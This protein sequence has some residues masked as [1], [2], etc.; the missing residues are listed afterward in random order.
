MV[1]RREME[2]NIIPDPDIDV[3]MKILGLDICEDT[4]VGNAILKGISK[5]QRKRVTIGETLVGPLKSLF[6]D[7]ISIGLDDS[8]AFQIVKSLKQFVY[9]L[10]RTAVISLQQ[11]SLET[12]NLFDD[13]I[14]LSDGHIVYQGPC[15]QVLDFFASIGFMCPERKPVVDFLQEVTSM[16]D[17]EQYWTHKEKPYIFVTAKEFADAFESYHVGKSLANELATQFDKSKSHPAALTTN[18]YGIGKLELFKACLSRDYLLMKRNSSHYIFKLLQIA[19][20]AIITMTVFLPT[21]THHDSVT[22]GGI[23]ASALFY[24]STV[25]MLNGFAELAMMVG[26]LPV[27]YKQRDLLFF[28]SWAYALPAWILRLPLNFAEVGV[29]V[30]FTYSIIGDPNVIGR[31]FLLL[32]LV[33]QMAGVFCRLVG[34]IGRETSMAATLATL[35][36][37]ML[38]VVVSQ[39]IE[40]QNNLVLYAYTDNIKK[41]WLWEF[42]ISPAMYGQNALLNNEFQGKTWRHVVPN[43]TEPLGVQV[44]KSRGFFTQSNWYWIGFGALIG[45][46]LLFIIGYILALTFL[47]PLKEHQVVESVQLLSR[48][49]KSVTENKHYGK[50]GMIL[51]FEPHC[52]TFD[53]VTYSVD[54]PQEMKN[55]R[56][57]GERLNLLN[58]VSG[59]FRPAVLTALMGVTGAGK[60]TLMDVLAGR[61]TRGYIGGTITISGY[62]KKQE[63]FARV[64]GYCEQNYI[65]SPYVTVYESLLFSAW[66]RL[67]AEINAETRKMFIEEVMELVEL[68]PLRDTIVVPGATGL[69]TLQRKRLTIAVELVA[70]P[71]IMFMD[72][73]TS[74]LDARSV[75]I[76]MRAIRN[77]VEN[78]RTVVCAIHQSNI[79][80]FE[81]FDELL[82]MKQGGQVIYAG[83]IGHHSSHLINYFEGIEGVSKIEDGC[84][85]AAWMLEITSSEKEMQLEIDFSEVYKNSELYRRNKALI[86]ELSIPAPDSVNLRFPSKYSRPLFAQFKACL[87]K[88]H[89]SYWRNPR[90]NALRFLFTAVASIFF[91]SVFYGLGSKIEKRQDLLNSIGSMSITILLIGI[92]NAGSV[93]AVVTAERA[94]FYR[95]NAARMYSPLAY[96]FGQASALVYGTI[97]YAMVGFEWS[98]TKFFWYIFF[99]FFTSLYCTYYGMM[100]IAITPN[101]TIVSFLTRPSYV[102]WNLFSGT[103]VPPPRIPIWWRWFYWANPMAWSLNGLVAS[104]FGGIKDHIEYNGKSVSVEDFLENYFGFQH[105]FLG[106]VAAVVVGFNVVFGLVFVMSIKMFNFQSR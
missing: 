20:V 104:Q 78:G 46:T 53:E 85:P 68:T 30:I 79:D 56:V 51:S 1:C 8:T 58:G 3:Y 67:S 95:E 4:M 91:G 29:W 97:V 28:P 71:S 24:G 106:V 66:L 13:I 96:A 88:Q 25:I 40:Q 31:T 36:L 48:K 34:A 69:S 86:V 77:I 37:G 2:E 83:P 6:V 98:V 39:D 105:E 75:A 35:S 33:N 100:T 70:N 93:Q 50:R 55:Q 32:V 89:W 45:Y 62:S 19:L 64:C 5:G 61:K 65:H 44:L 57:V 41:W 27:F 17:Q 76:V 16:K 49:K 9:L 101:Q 43:S 80:I 38:L 87:W 74:G 7:D 10:K 52:I 11:P 21:R 15:V 63:T 23:Y 103:V 60:T 14:L 92:K 84:N 81:S 72:E 54:M 47:N 26:R 12:Y 59:S 22:D 102:L 94:V 73:P 42:W 82:L 99:V 90:Y 18:K